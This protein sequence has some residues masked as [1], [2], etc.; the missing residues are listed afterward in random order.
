MNIK[1]LFSALL[2][3]RFLRFLLAGGVGSTVYMFLLYGLTEW[4]GVVYLTSSIIGATAGNAI[5]FVIQKFWTFK[6]NDLK[7]AHWQSLL[8]FIKAL[9]LLGL[10]TLFLWLLVEKFYLNY[11]TAQLLIVPFAT[12]ISFIISKRIFKNKNPDV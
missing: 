5:N 6:N 12:L 11:L 8:F 7:T 10:N 1:N 4:F 2:K 3:S 9:F